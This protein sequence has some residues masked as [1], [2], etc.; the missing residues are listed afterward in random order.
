MPHFSLSANGSNESPVPYRDAV[1]R[2]SVCLL[3]FDRCVCALCRN[4]ECVSSWG[5]WSKMFGSLVHKGFWGSDLDKCSCGIPGWGQGKQRMCEVWGLYWLPIAA[6][7][8]Y[9]TLRSTVLAYL[10]LSHLCRCQS[11]C[12]EWPLPLI[13][14]W[15]VLTQPLGL[16]SDIA[17]SRKASLKHTH[18]HPTSGKVPRHN[19]LHVSL[20]TQMPQPSAT[21]SFCNRP[22]QGVLQLDT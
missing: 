2:W 21:I 19:T 6:V 10:W 20:S 14:N 7:T 5:S 11:P 13:S 4:I 9:H 18:H 15:L 16:N 12:L 22:P 3:Q 8:I 1:S 17:S